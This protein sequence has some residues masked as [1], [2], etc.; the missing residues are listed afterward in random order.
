PKARCDPRTLSAY[1]ELHIEQGPHLETARIPIGVVEGIVGI[2]R[3]RLT[4]IGEPDH[5]GTTPMARRKDAFLGAADYA[6]S[7]REHIVKKGRGRSGNAGGFASPSPGAAGCAWR[8]S[9]CR[10][11]SPPAAPPV[12]SP[13]WSGRARRSGSSPGAC[14][15]APATT[16]R[17]WPR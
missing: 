8:S 16:P 7:A 15:P 9:P 6:L 17:T 1:V 12:S 11:P 14:R 13:P 5:A 4:F 3:D 10:A 2:H